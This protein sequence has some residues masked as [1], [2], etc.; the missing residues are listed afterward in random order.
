[1]DTVCRFRAEQSCFFE[2][3]L[4]EVAAEDSTKKTL[5]NAREKVVTKTSVLD[6]TANYGSFLQELESTADSIDILVFENT[7]ETVPC[8]V[9]Y[10]DSKEGCW[11]DGIVS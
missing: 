7:S 5:D 10:C 1:M 4:Q 2:V 11:I 8:F 3:F 9:L 6:T